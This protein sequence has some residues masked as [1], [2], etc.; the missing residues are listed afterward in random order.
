MICDTLRSLREQYGM[1][2]E[3]V[4]DVLGIERSTYAYYETSRV[5]SVETLTKLARLYNTSLDLL[6]GLPSLP[7]TKLTFS[8]PGES[9]ADEDAKAFPLT[10][11]E[12]KAVLLFRLCADRQAALHLLREESL[13]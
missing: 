11:E 9:E 2:Q 1:T 4:S 10:E 5:P 8:A 6:A 12:K 3:Q 7:G 13:R